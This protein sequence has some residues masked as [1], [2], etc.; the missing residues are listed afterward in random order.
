MQLDLLEDARIHTEA[1]PRFSDDIPCEMAVPVKYSP[2]GQSVELFRACGMSAKWRLVIR[3]HHVFD[4]LDEHVLCD[5]H[6]SIWQ[7]FKA[8]DD[9]PWD[10][11][12]LGQM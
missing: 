12:F 7:T 3:F 1:L 5:Q 10:I 11:A 6:L 4:L 8:I 2:D 9:P